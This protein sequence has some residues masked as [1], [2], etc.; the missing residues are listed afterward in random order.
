MHEM[1]EVMGRVGSVGKAAGAGVYTPLDLFRY[2]A[3][4]MSGAAAGTQRATTA[5]GLADFFSINGGQTNLG[6]YN[7]AT[8]AQGDYSDWSTKQ[9]G[10]PFGEATHGP[11]PLTGRDAIE[12]AVIGYNLSTSGKTL[13]GTAQSVSA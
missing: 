3:K 13:A 10:D 2:Q 8:G 4:S 1:T 6:Y 9:L 12:M 5:G 7:A 11:L